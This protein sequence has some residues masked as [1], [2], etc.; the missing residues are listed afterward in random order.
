MAPYVWSVFLLTAPKVTS[1]MRRVNVT[2]IDAR[3]TI[4]TIFHEEVN[5]TSPSF[6]LA[7]T[8]S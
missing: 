2:G 7:N 3:C 6:R 8:R 5:P 4:V 1:P